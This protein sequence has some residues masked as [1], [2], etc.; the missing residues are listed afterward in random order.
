[1]TVC[2][3]CGGP[4]E[5]VSIEDPRLAGKF[6]PADRPVFA[7]TSCLQPY[8]WNEREN[9]SPARAMKVAERLHKLIR[10]DENWR[11]GGIFKN[12]RL[13]EEYGVEGVEG[14]EAGVEGIEARVEGVGVE[15]EEVNSTSLLSSACT[16][17][18]AADTTQL[19]TS[20]LSAL[21]RQRDATIK[22]KKNNPQIAEAI[23]I[24]DSVL[25]I[26]QSAVSGV[27]VVSADAIADTLTSTSTST[28]ISTSTTSI[29]TSTSTR[30]QH[31]LPRLDSLHALLHG[32]EAPFTNWNGD[33]RGTL[34]YLFGSPDWTVKSCSVVPAIR[35]STSSNSAERVE[36][37]LAAGGDAE[38]EEVDLAVHGGLPNHLWASDHLMVVGE[39]SLNMPL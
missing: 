11:G 18:S 31:P 39:V 30:M 24:S 20:Q 33:F 21:F 27:A 25:R 13:V 34:D 38:K 8:W 28:S 37:D 29:S 3:K 35:N 15:G 10:G 6:L 1:M 19:S 26:R 16:M 4:I 9:S 12:G 23:R 14:I 5:A 2:G 22:A 17:T 32:S 36:Q 7:C